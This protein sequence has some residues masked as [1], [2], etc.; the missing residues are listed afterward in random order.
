[1]ADSEIA[2]APADIKLGLPADAMS[3]PTPPSPLL[4]P[5]ARSSA[6]SPSRM[7][8]S[9][10]SPSPPPSPSCSKRR[11]LDAPVSGE[12]DRRQSSPAAS[13]RLDD[14]K[15]GQK[16][17][18]TSYKEK[19][20]QYLEE[21]RRLEE[22]F[23]TSE[24]SEKP[25]MTGVL[26]LRNSMKNW[27]SVWAVLRPGRLEYYKESN[28]SDWVG[29]LLLAGC[30]VVERPSKKDGFCF[31]IFNAYRS[32]IHAEKGPA[33]ET[34]YTATN[35]MPTDYCICRATD[36]DLGHEWLAAISET[37]ELT[38]TRGMSR[39]LLEDEHG[40]FPRRH[41][42][43]EMDF[44]MLSPTRQR[45][46]LP[47][48]VD[49]DQAGLSRRSSN[50]SQM[51]IMEE[52]VEEDEWSLADPADSLVCDYDAGMQA[53]LWAQFA[54]VDFGAKLPVSLLPAELLQPRSLLDRCSD[55]FAIAGLLNAAAQKQEP[56]GRLLG[57]CGWL[58]GVLAAHAK[59]K[60]VDIP[61]QPLV[62][63]QFRCAFDS[64]QPNTG[65]TYFVAEQ[66]SGSPACSAVF[67][68][69]RKA[70]WVVEGDFAYASSF[71][72]NLIVCP[73]SGTLEVRLLESQ[74]TYRVIMPAPCV[75]GLIIAPLAGGWHGETR[76]TCEK[77]GLECSFVF[78]PHVN[79]VHD[80]VV[81]QAG[82]ASGGIA[83]PL[84]GGQVV[85]FDSARP[86]TP[87]EDT[88]NP[89]VQIVYDGGAVSP[90]TRLEVAMS[91]QRALTDQGPF[92]SQ[93]TWQPVVAAMASGEFETA[94]LA[95]RELTDKISTREP[96]LF[97]RQDGRW[98]YSHSTE[99]SWSVG[100][101]DRYEYMRNG[102]LH[103]AGGRSQAP[104]RPSTRTPTRQSSRTSDVAIS[105]VP[106]RTNSTT[107]T[108]SQSEGVAS[109]ELQR[110]MNAM[111][112]VQEQQTAALAQVQQELKKLTAQLSTTLPANGA[113]APQGTIVVTQTHVLVIVIAFVLQMLVQMLFA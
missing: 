113:R 16:K 79:E 34:W 71:F 56:L 1:M 8:T 106:K 31:K 14:P 22:E 78:D 75:H 66:V 107:R 95:I 63:E 77:T 74:E 102:E 33:G 55:A 60:G 101:R 59:P 70:G 6:E 83:G 9:T 104:A 108:E 94:E 97:V 42:T 49:E 58:C 35:M 54:E 46:K 38:L 29:T 45:S 43:G 15:S 105:I 3:N 4:I 67:A 27:K 73:H 80:G 112:L 103:V 82:Q 88:D 64:D 47:L 5:R 2:A 28:H 111:V 98:R 84:A 96:T 40:G 36:E 48:I 72:G 44:S 90:L 100:T 81:M 93:R 41:S 39:S 30:Q 7:R 17:M 62:G 89:D 37:I 19:R 110:K 92:D 51:S 52:D 32:N 99:Q 13:L 18:K 68:S 20:K 57:V 91:E 69:N 65:R 53:S 11:L 21:K 109:R 24:R 12:F 85:Y 10:P 76:I 26:K 50:A 86:S 23:L 25:I 61:M 87:V